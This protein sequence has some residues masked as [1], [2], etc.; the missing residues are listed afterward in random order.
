MQLVKKQRR[1]RLDPEAR[2]AQLLNCSLA[3]FAEHGIA[4][5]THSQIAAKAGMSVS[6][7]YS[8]FRTRE[9][10][11][12]ATLGEV[13]C[14]L[15]RIFEQAVAKNLSPFEALLDI[16]RIF[17]EG[18]KS[19]PDIIR[20]LLDWSTG[21]GL[22]VWPNYLKMLGRLEETIKDILARGKAEGVVPAHIDIPTAARI[23]TGGGHTVAL[24]QC[25]K[26]APDELNRFIVQLVCGAMGLSR[27]P[28]PESGA[29]PA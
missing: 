23:F 27:P 20:V 18:A 14:Y 17:A 12:H 21:V 8:Y 5:A 16:G 13:E 11:V 29:Q 1:T 28:P 25:A 9:D 3:V 4:R 6:A 10:L 7:V 2:R 22:E 24:M 26:I 19:Q 15:D